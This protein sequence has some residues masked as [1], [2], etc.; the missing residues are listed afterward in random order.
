M[1]VAMLLIAL[2]GALTWAYQQKKR[3]EEELSKM[4]K[5]MESLTKAEQM[6]QEMQVVRF[7]LKFFFFFFI[8][9]FQIKLQFLDKVISAARSLNECRIYVDIV[10]K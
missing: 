10:K 6:L 2:I 8:E 9:N 5:D 4:I 1:I 7:V 3:S